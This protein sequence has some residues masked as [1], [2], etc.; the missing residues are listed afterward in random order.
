[1][2]IWLLPSLEGDEVSG[3]VAPA[4]IDVPGSVNVEVG[5]DASLVLDGVR[6]IPAVFVFE[7]VPRADPG[8]EFAE[9]L[10]DDVPTAE[11]GSVATAVSLGNNNS[12]A[13]A[14]SADADEEAAAPTLSG[15]TLN[16]FDTPMKEVF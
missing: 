2:I 3:V 16:A 4:E 8:N 13:D 11:P 9:L 6:E 7:V 12:E 1:M 10:V 14:S 15:R 5:L